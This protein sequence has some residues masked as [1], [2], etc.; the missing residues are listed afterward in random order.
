MPS[1][2][3]SRRAYAQARGCSERAVRKAIQRG[4]IKPLPSGKID[5]DQ[6]DE[7]WYKW[8]PVSV[9][10]NR[11]PRGPRLSEKA[12]RKGG[13]SSALDD[14]ELAALV[15]H[16]LGRT[17]R[18]ELSPIDHRFLTLLGEV[19]AELQAL[20]RELGKVIEQVPQITAPMYRIALHTQ[21]CGTP[22]G[23]SR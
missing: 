14:P 21:A 15:D 2:S 7:G 5:P 19:K 10:D 22:F 17:E 9:R 6:A 4:R 20:R 3:L 13:E 11:Q 1:P 8:S 18:V 23:K 12:S 16:T